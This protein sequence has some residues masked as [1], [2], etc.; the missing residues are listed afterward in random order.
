MSSVSGGTRGVSGERLTGAMCGFTLTSPDGTRLAHGPDPSAY[1]DE[2][3]WKRVPTTKKFKPIGASKRVN[4]TVD[5]EYEVN[6]KGGQVGQG[7]G[8]LCSIVDAHIKEN[9]LPPTL[10]L[11]ATSGG[12]PHV[13]S[14]GLTWTFDD[15]DLG[16]AQGTIPDGMNTLTN[17]V[18]ITFSS[19]VSS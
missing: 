18:T 6:I 15:G 19:F 3:T 17:E 9:K 7:W 10:K 12:L 13:A 5:I 16:A 8:Y 4:Q 11:V 2:V 14:S 1:A